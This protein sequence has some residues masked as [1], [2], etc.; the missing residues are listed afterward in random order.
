LLLIAI[1]A[2]SIPPNLLVAIAPAAVVTVAVTQY[3]LTI[4]VYKLYTNYQVFF[5]F[6][7]AA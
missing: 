2:E 3:K 1:E 4:V 5:T 7:K 6:C